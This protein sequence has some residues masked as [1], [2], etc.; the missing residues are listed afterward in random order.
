MR[1]IRH[2]ANRALVDPKRPVQPGIASGITC[3][4]TDK[5]EDWLGASGVNLVYGGYPYDPC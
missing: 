2:G 3:R 5:L 4:T 1:K